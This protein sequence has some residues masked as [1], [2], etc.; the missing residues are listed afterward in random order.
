M[1]Y[2]HY[3]LYQQYVASE[4]ML[5]SEKWIR[6]YNL[7]LEEFNNLQNRLPKRFFSE[8]KKT[9]FHDFVLS[10]FELQKEENKSGKSKHK[11]IMQLEDCQATD[12]YHQ[13]FFYDV[14][15]VQ[16]NLSFSAFAGSCDWLY[17]EILPVNDQYLS[18]EII[19]FDSSILYFDFKKMEYKK[20]RMNTKGR[21]S[22]VDERD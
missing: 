17:A 12:Y 18:F 21:F 7:W 1:K 15:Q 13:L 11:L 22:C 14:G 8:Y 6:Q 10:F 9:E 20:V 5:I 16:A 2:L 4:N 19:L 3:D